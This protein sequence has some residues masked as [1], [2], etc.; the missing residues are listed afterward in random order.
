MASTI[1]AIEQKAAMETVT[2]QVQA[3]EHSS[4]VNDDKRAEADCCYRVVAI[5]RSMRDDRA[6]DDGCVQAMEA[7]SAGDGCSRLMKNETSLTKNQRRVVEQQRWWCWLLP[8]TIVRDN[9][10]GE[11]NDKEKK[12]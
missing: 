6:E 7:A 5:Q 10:L 11:R 9:F 3:I 12:K 2:L 4:T 1:P 8:A